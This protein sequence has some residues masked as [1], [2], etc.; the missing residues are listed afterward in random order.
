MVKRFFGKRKLNII[1]SVA[2]LVLIA[3]VWIITYY[4]VKNDYIIPSLG[5]T[6]KSFFKCLGEQ[7]FWT[8]FGL[9]FLRTA[10]GFIISFALALLCAALSYCSKIFS[11]VLRP[12]MVILRTLPTLAVILILLV[13]TTPKIAP[14]IV[15]VLVLFPMIYS[16]ITAAAEGIDGGLKE[17]ADIYQIS[18][19][20]RLFKIYLPSASPNVLSQTGAD[21]SLGLKIMVSAE[22]L[23]A[24]YKSLGGL[25]QTAKNVYYDMPRL[26]A[27]TIAAIII[28]FIVEIAFSQLARI[29]Y[30]WSRKEGGY[31]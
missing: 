29:T 1:C 13:W 25:M 10:T 12:F 5:E 6:F 2:A 24:T 27:L 28:G 19:K 3:L 8:A 4:S 15:T 21:L 9:T 20:D 16:Q 18:K 23:C 14:V 26:A 17:M 31:D 7:T 30:K 11:A 22:V